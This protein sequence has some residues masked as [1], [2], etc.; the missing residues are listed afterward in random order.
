MV[1]AVMAHDG[2]QAAHRCAHLLHY[3]RDCE[4][5]GGVGCGG[6]AGRGDRDVEAAR[7]PDPAAHRVGLAARRA[8][9]GGAGHPRGGGADGGVAASG[10]A[11]VGPV[12]A[13][14][15][16]RKPDLLR[17]CERARRTARDRGALPRGSPDIAGA[18]PP[19]PSGES[20]RIMS[21]LHDPRRPRPRRAQRAQSRSRSRRH[22]RRGSSRRLA[23]H[24]GRGVPSPQS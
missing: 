7:R 5:S 19:S 23:G 20:Q 6:A 11:A 15:P 14:T 13:D 21:T 2:L 8:L 10:Q 12:S 18:R 9:G 1:A 17:G 24:A 22:R 4:Y 16:R 3:L